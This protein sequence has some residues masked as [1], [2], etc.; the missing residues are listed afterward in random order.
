MRQREP[1]TGR[2]LATISAAASPVVRLLALASGI[3]L[4]VRT[5]L[6][7]GRSQRID[8]RQHLPDQIDRLAGLP[9]CRAASEPATPCCIMCTLLRDRPDAADVRGSILRS[10][11]PIPSPRASRIHLDP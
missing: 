3:A 10:N 9:G 4:H 1:S 5:A 6:A 2:A 11:R 8:Y 7:G